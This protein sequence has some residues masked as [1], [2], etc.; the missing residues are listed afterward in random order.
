MLQS[1]YS[2]TTIVHRGEGGAETIR[3]P[4]WPAYGEDTIGICRK[5]T[6]SKQFSELSFTDQGTH[7]MGHSPTLKHLTSNDQRKVASE[8]TFTGLS[9]CLRQAQRQGADL[10]RLSQTA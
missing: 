5:P 8:S 7:I 6:F 2:K 1:V 4:P 3:N 10:L 9:N